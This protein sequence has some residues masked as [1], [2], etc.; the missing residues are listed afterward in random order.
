[1][2]RRMTYHVVMW[3]KL[4]AD[5]QKKVSDTFFWIADSMTDEQYTTWLSSHGYYYNE[6]NQLQIFDVYSP[7]TIKA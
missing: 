1:M 6:Y 5:E 2:K 7:D 3:A 4:S